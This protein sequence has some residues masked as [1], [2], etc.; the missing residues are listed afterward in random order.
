MS[1]VKKKK[2]IGKIQPS[3]CPT[4]E[5]SSVKCLERVLPTAKELLEE[6]LAS[7]ELRTNHGAPSETKKGSNLKQK[8]PFVPH[9]AVKTNRNPVLFFCLSLLFF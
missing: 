3:A 9:S 2:K 5:K 6:A 1:A 7:R 8:F 4:D